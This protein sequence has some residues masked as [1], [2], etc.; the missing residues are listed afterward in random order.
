MLEPAA[1]P[2][3]LVAAPFVGSFLSVLAVR[4]PRGEDI[5]VSRSKCRSCGKAL[6]PL[7]LIPIASWVAQGGKCRACGAQVG[8]LYPGMEVGAAVVVVWAATAGMSDVMFWA[9]VGLGWVLLT[10]AVMDL[11][12]FILADA[13]T[14]PL[15]VAGL[16][17]MAW[18]V[19][20][21]V[22]WH[23]LGAAGGFALMVGVGFAYT[24]VRGREGLGFGDAKL[25]AAAGAW[26]GLEGVGTVLLYGAVLSR[27]F[28]RTFEA[29]TPIPFGAGLAAGFWL[30]WLYGPL[31]V[32]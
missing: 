26:T 29:D 10:L 11:R 19:P 25:M 21:A 18:Q 4:L 31:L 16:G 28:G 24:A 2:I 13:L 23:A 12:D 30:T 7:E 15:V 17:L 22:L 1:W 6:S 32:G 20:E 14:L 27:L 8:W 3:A 9:T 5:V